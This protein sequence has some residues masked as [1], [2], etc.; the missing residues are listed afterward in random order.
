MPIDMCL[1]RERTRQLKVT[2]QADVVALSVLFWDRFP[3]E[4]HEANFRY[5]EPRTAHGSSLSPSFH[6]LV[7]ARLGDGELFERYFHQSAE[8]DLADNMG[9]AAAGVHIGALGGLWQAAVFGVAGLRL[10]EGGLALDPHL[11]PSWR[12][13]AFQ[14]K[15]RG[16][17]VAIALTAEPRRV[18]V[19]IRGEPGMLLELP[20]TEPAAPAPGKRW[21]A[22]RGG[23][24]WEGWEEAP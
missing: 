24:G 22:R 18:T 15:W 20:K 14:V 6:A 19:E 12:S 4:V 13:L 2:K 11:P 21:S 1:G 10:R 3:R 16:R 9:N 23:S 8:I 5:Y 17:E 7:A